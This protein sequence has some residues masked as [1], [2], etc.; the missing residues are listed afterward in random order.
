[1][2]ITANNISINEIA[3]LLGCKKD[4]ASIRDCETI[5]PWAKYKP[6]NYNL[7]AID[8]PWDETDDLE[9]SERAEVNYGLTLP[10]KTTD[11][12]MIPYSAKSYT[13]TGDYPKYGIYTPTDRLRGVMRLRDFIGYEHTGGP[14][15]VV[16]MDETVYQGSSFKTSVEYK[17]ASSNHI[18]LTDIS[19]DGTAVASWYVYYVFYTKNSNGTYYPYAICNTGCIVKNCSANMYHPEVND[20]NSWD[21]FVTGTTYTAMAVASPSNKG[22]VGQVYNVSDSIVGS[23]AMIPLTLNS[24]D[25]IFEFTVVK[26][27]TLPDEEVA[28]TLLE[29][30]DYNSSSTDQGKTDMIFDKLGTTITWMEPYLYYKWNGE[31]TKFNMRLSLVTSTGVTA[32]STNIRVETGSNSDNYLQYSDLASGNFEFTNCSLSP[33]DITG[34]QFELQYPDITGNYY[35]IKTVRAKV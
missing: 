14:D 19:Y 27:P 26:N 20:V 23:L 30:G 15:F 25:A 5:N 13:W 31:G 24:R 11:F 29:L 33:S 6:I 17:S 18:N 2:A 4:L 3:N 7:E 22:T 9:D 34:I 10:G 21:C 28:L 16:S 12:E 32:Y 1:M 8:N 35:V